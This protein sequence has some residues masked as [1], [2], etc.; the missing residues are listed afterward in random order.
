[1]HRFHIFL[2]IEGIVDQPAGLVFEARLK[3]LPICALIY[4]MSRALELLRR[5]IAALF[6]GELECCPSWADPGAV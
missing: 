1:M 4:F 5:D 2:A 3:F 6:G